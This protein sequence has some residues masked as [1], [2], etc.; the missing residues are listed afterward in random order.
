MQGINFQE[1]FESNIK[2]L[3]KET[4][5]DEPYIRKLLTNYTY[6]CKWANVNPFDEDLELSEFFRF[7][8]TYVLDYLT[9]VLEPDEFDITKYKCN[10]KTVIELND[11]QAERK[12]III[13]NIFKKFFDEEDFKS[14]ITNE[15]LFKYYKYAVRHAGLKLR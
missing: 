11:L 13:D 7:E 10:S 8:I 12:P 2:R 14:V 3:I 5:P 15:D 9:G 1:S 4:G 6:C